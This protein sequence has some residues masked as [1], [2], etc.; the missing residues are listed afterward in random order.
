MVVS[1][2]S[3]YFLLGSSLIKSLR[4]PLAKSGPMAFPRFEILRMRISN[5]VYLFD[6]DRERQYSDIAWVS[7]S[8][9]R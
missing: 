8:S 1:S 4:I 5:I 2:I 6:G 9:S 3:S 7:T